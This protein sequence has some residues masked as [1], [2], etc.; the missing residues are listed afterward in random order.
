MLSMYS[1]VEVSDSL[2]VRRGL[3]LL[4]PIVRCIMW[5][6]LPGHEGACSCCWKGKS[7]R[8]YDHVIC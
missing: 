6:T 3:R 1:Q 4:D 8:V 7:G 5:A 2:G